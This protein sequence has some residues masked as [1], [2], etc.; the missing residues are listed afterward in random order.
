[1]RNEGA[2][3]SFFFF[4]LLGRASGAVADSRIARVLFL[5]EHVLRW[6]GDTPQATLNFF[7]LLFNLPSECSSFESWR[8]FHVLLA[9][10]DDADER[11]LF[12]S[13]STLHSS[14]SSPSYL[15]S[16]SQSF[17]RNASSCKFFSLGLLIFCFHLVSPRHRSCFY[18]FSRQR[19]EE[20]RLASERK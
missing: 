3:C 7:F 6:F 11:N 5:F 10:W 8:P 1:M 4:F 17:G 13:Y 12:F 9:T 2:R 19:R 15:S 14:L 18:C 20:E 16:S